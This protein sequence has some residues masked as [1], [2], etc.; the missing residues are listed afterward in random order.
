MDLIYELVLQ[1]SYGG[2]LGRENKGWK[3]IW[4]WK[5]LERINF[6]LWMVGHERL[7]TNERRAKW[8]LCS[9]NC[10]ICENSIEN[11]LHVLRDC[12]IAKDI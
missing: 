1:E 2:I 11:I 12:P 9:P 5:G 10:S 3:V 7:C 4:M 8:S 6:F